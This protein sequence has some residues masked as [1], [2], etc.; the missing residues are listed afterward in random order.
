MGY[1]ARLFKKTSLSVRIYMRFVLDGTLLSV[2]VATIGEMV[3]FGT[4]AS[5]TSVS[6]FRFRGGITVM[7]CGDNLQYYHDHESTVRKCFCTHDEDPDFDEKWEGA[8]DFLLR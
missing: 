4:A 1:A 5:P 6:A 7:L 2:R 8:I 3:L